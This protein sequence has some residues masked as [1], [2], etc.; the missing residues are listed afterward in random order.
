MRTLPTGS[1]HLIICDSPYG[2]TDLPFDRQPV[3]W[4]AWW[5]EAK[6]VLAPNGVI[7]CFA[8]E[9]F[10]LDL[11]ASN[12]PWYRY[13]MVWVKSKASR[14]CDTP[15]RPLTTHEDLVV[16]APAI[17][18]ATYNPQKKPYTGPAKNTKRKPVTMGHYKGQRY[19]AEYVDDGTRFPTTVLE[20]A[21]IG[22]G[23]VHLNK[24][25]K[26]V[27]LI[28]EL[29]LTFSNRGDVVL[30]PFAGDAP[31]GHACEN[32]GRRYYGCEIDP[33]QYEWSAVQLVK[34]STLFS[35]EPIA[36]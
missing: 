15:W 10:T 5:A 8:C 27:P 14:Y 18:A 36:A 26:P 33:I 1:V 32:T 24:T 13:R 9:A 31:T 35:I 20:Y 19:A 30:E 21:S 11:I 3:N 4:P 17:K 34:K 6:R 25:A 23:A 2:N 22:S 16:F 7:I 12:R 28:Q 29:V